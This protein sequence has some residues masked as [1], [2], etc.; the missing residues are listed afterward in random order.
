MPVNAGYE[1]G[2]AQQKLSEAKTPEDKIKALEYLLSVSPTHKGT[3]TMRSEFKSKI[4][5]LRKQIEKERTSKK[6]AGFSFAIKKEG[7]AQ[8][9]L[10]G[11]PNSG[12][13]TILKRFTKAQAEIA[14]Y[15]F[16]TKVPEVGVMEFEG[17]KIQ[18]IELPAVFPGYS[19]SE[20]GPSFLSIAK[21]ADLVCLVLDGTRDSKADLA[22]LEKELKDGA[23]VLQKRNVHDPLARRG[24]L[25]MNKDLSMFSSPYPIC[26]VDDFAQAV[27]GRLGLI[28]VRTKLPGKEP[29][30]PPVALEKGSTVKDLALKV[31]KDLV[32]QFQ[33]ARIWGKSVKHSGLSVG[34]EHVLAE[35]DIV[36]VHTKQ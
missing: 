9:V 17:I 28:W 16:T 1:F 10:L 24:L 27:W 8:V 22:L 6:G 35:G 14:A 12:K 25:I 34:V 15:E 31:H 7:A 13:S 26:W 11:L 32:K 4:A 3:E 23:L 20:K 5:K 18:V 29:A 36:E 30:W 19:H 2:L 33:Y 21:S